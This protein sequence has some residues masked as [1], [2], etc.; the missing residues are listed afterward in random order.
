M[1][2]IDKVN[3]A[4]E[5][6]P[7]PAI[8]QAREDKNPRE[9]AIKHLAFALYNHYYKQENNLLVSG[10]QERW[11][12]ISGISKK[13]R[14]IG[15]RLTDLLVEKFEDGKFSD[16]I[17]CE[18]K[19][20]T[21]PKTY[22]DLLDQVSEVS[23]YKITSSTNEHVFVNVIYGTKISFFKMYDVETKEANYKDLVPIYPQN[24]RESLKKMGMITHPDKDGPIYA[25]EM[26]LSIKEHWEL[27]HAC[28]IIMSRA[29]G[30]QD[31]EVSFWVFIIYLSITNCT[32]VLVLTVIAYFV[33]YCFYLFNLAIITVK[34]EEHKVKLPEQSNGIWL[35]HGMLIV[36]FY[37][38]FLFSNS[39]ICFVF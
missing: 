12:I 8:T 20:L 25:C 23:H 24:N 2:A 16:L 9:G 3:S 21:G 37:K 1:T 10:E 36:M 38:L 11:P 26:D 33:F 19:R 30:P 13:N 7:I 32:L 31:P 27:I 4:D 35:Q 14:E 28:F 5:V 18:A 39:V 29:A 22:N 17:F 15:V 34:V 6:G